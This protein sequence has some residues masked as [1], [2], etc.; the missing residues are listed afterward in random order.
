M[1]KN[2]LKITTIICLVLMLGVV[3]TGCGESQKKSEKSVEFKSDDGSI[4]LTADSAWKDDVSLSPESS[5]ELSNAAEEKYV[6]VIEESKESLTDDFTLTDYTNLMKPQM[7]TTIVDC[8]SSEIEE[9]TVNGNAA[10]KFEL[11][12]EVD[13]IKATYI[14]YAVESTDNFYQVISWTLTPKLE[15]NKEDLLKVMNSFKVIN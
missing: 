10:Q 6:I 12:G 14:C 9:I 3:V 4:S 7:E 11:S 2:R 15:D 13:K 8:K 1:K 5:I